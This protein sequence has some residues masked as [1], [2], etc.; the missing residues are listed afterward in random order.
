MVVDMLDVQHDNPKIVVHFHRLDLDLSSNEFS[1]QSRFQLK[2]KQ[3]FRP[4]IRYHR[5][6]SEFLRFEIHNLYN[7]QNQQDF[8]S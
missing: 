6:I 3:F 4:N 5:I 7:C 1:F 8:E 2:N